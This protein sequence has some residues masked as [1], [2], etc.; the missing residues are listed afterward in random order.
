MTFSR[1]VVGRKTFFFS[2]FFFLFLTKHVGSIFFPFFVFGLEWIESFVSL[3]LV[4]NGSWFMAMAR[5]WA[6]I[7]IGFGGVHSLKLFRT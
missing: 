3:S 5:Q 1:S 7:H 4:L 2:F 6:C